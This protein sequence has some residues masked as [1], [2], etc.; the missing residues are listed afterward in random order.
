MSHRAPAD[1]LIDQRKISCNKDGDMAADVFGT[2]SGIHMW[3]SQL[4]GHVA[5]LTCLPIK[6]FAKLMVQ[7]LNSTR[8]VKVRLAGSGPTKLRPSRY[9]CVERSKT[10]GIKQR[11]GRCHKRHATAHGPDL[12]PTPPPPTRT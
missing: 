10:E 2:W 1:A 5:K 6:S 9:A 3:Q 8:L 7:G 11:A 4:R 12:I